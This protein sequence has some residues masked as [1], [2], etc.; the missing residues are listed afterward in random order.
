MDLLQAVS[1]AEIEA[2]RRLVLEY[3]KSLGF[4]LCFQRSLRISQQAPSEAGHDRKRPYGPSRVPR[5]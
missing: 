4:D 1:P 5:L 3:E 2:V